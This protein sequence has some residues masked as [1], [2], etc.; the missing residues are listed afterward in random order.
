MFLRSLLLSALFSTA[1][2]ANTEKAIFLGPRAVDVPSAVAAAAGASADPTSEAAALEGDLRRIHVLTPDDPQVRT[3]LGAQ[4]PSTSYPRGK[5]TWL[6]LAG[7]AE[8]RRYEVRV[9]WVA[10]VS[11]I[12]VLILFFLSFWADQ[13]RRHMSCGPTLI[14][15]GLKRRGGVT[16]FL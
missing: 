9:C 5:P 8:G 13:H 4:F 6:A 15:S 12:P 14:T 10:T 7:L 2:H 16:P 11:F 3:H 1:V